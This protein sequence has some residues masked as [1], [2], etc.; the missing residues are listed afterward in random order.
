MLFIDKPVRIASRQIE[1]KFIVNTDKS[2]DIDQTAMM[3]E[4]GNSKE[5]GN[6]ILRKFYKR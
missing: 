4:D 5:I 2:V 3:I 6:E 1:I